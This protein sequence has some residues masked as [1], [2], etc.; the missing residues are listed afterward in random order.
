MEKFNSITSCN[1]RNALRVLAATIVLS[2]ISSHSFA[3]VGLALGAKGGIGI[4]T[5]KGTDAENI[6]SRTS[7]LGGAFLN[8]QISPVFNL[9]PEI[10]F[11]QKG[12]DY[13]ANGTRSQLVINYFEVPVLAKV[14]LPVGDVFFPHILFGPNFAFKTNVKYSSEETG[15]G[16]QVTTNDVDIRKSDIGALAGVGIDIEP[17]ESGLFFTIDGRYGFG[18]NS[19][20][21]SE[22]AVEI[23]NAGWSFAVG[24]GFI[25]KKKQQ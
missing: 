6:D 9:Q 4:T 3:Q 12:A 13:S 7:W 5:F 24:V 16:T 1:G 14:R 21:G 15:G 19:V 18:F 10:L 11:S 2:I 20:D 25:L 17:R 8:A 22:N 23:R